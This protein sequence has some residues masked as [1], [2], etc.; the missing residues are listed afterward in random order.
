M[1]LYH[2]GTVIQLS[3][4]QTIP[5]NSAPFA[6]F[7]TSLTVPAPSFPRVLASAPLAQG[8]FLRL[9]EILVNCLNNGS[10]LLEIPVC[11]ALPLPFREG[12][13]NVLCDCFIGDESNLSTAAELDGSVAGVFIKS[14]GSFSCWVKVRFRQTRQ[15]QYTV[16]IPF[17]KRQIRKCTSPINI[18]DLTRNRPIV[19]RSIE[20]SGLKLD[21]PRSM[22]PLVDDRSTKQYK[23]V[24]EPLG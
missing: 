18:C 7:V 6:R 8:L 14:S 15:R 13:D 10:V 24:S 11:L 16:Y 2:Q 9:Q 19:S 5:L 21:N 3:N 20:N 12:V 23:Y 22:D 4:L 1:V 17:R